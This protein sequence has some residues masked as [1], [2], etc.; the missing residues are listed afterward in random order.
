MNIFIAS[1][2]ESKK[3]LDDLSVIIE[4]LGH[5]VLRWDEPGLFVPGEST[6]ISLMKIKKDVD[7]AIMVYSPDDKVWF[8]EQEKE[9]PRDNVLFEHGLFVGSLG[10]NKAIIITTNQNVKIPTDL[11]GL[12]HIHF[13]KNR[14][15]IAKRELETWLNQLNNLNNTITD[16]NINFEEPEIKKFLQNYEEVSSDIY[17][18]MYY[19]SNSIDFDNT[20]TDLC[21]IQILTS[22]VEYFWGRPNARFTVRQYDA[23]S[24]TMITRLTTRQKRLPGDISLSK[25]NMI[26]E[27][28]KKKKPLIYSEHPE[29]H[30]RTCNN[31]IG[32]KYID[33]VSYALQNDNNGIP[34]FSVCLDVK[35][36]RDAT[37]LKL[38]VHTGF[39]EYICS[40]INKKLYNEIKKQDERK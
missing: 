6:M 30:F 14:K 26:T 12:T 18:Y 5:Q 28:A 31:S 40:L 17:E 35:D 33:Y 25:N 16:N 22:F 7:A 29:Y 4:Q 9:Q 23:K 8:R 20:T 2:M 13:S 21:V 27:S 15:N 19:I 1:S 32:T 39:F 36:N 37:R 24:N 3:I 38:L 34:M 10:H 11:F